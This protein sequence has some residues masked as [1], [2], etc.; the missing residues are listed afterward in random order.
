MR[1][2][3]PARQRA[4]YLLV[5]FVLT[6]RFN[7]L[8]PFPLPQHGIVGPPLGISRQSLLLMEKIPLR[9]KFEPHRRVA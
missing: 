2:T 9:G 6:K 5:A 8:V 3:F 1:L 7:P 4:E